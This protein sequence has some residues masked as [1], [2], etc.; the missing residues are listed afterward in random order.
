[1]LGA[2]GSTDTHFGTPGR[3]AEASYDR[4]ISTLLAT[5]E[6]QLGRLDFNPGGLVAVWAN[7]NTRADVFDALHRREAYAT[8]GPRIALKFGVVGADFCATP[9]HR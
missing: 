7:A 8:S 9:M 1:M 3:V 2:I 5:D 6:Q 4:G